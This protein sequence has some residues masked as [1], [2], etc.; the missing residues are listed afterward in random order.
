M[1]YATL[2]AGCVDCPEKDVVVLDFDHVTGVKKYSISYMIGSGF[3]P[4]VIKEEM[5]KCVVRCAN[6]HRRKTA[7]DFNWR[8]LLHKSE[9]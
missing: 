1:V 4:E 8:R 9:E 6:C 7:R 3:Y 5:S 2:S